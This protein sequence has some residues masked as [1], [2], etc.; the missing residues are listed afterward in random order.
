ML[1]LPLHTSFKIR[2]DALT[3][4]VVEMVPFPASIGSFSRMKAFMTLFL[5]LPDGT[6]KMGMFGQ[7]DIS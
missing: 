7:F 2:L 4:P 3:D 5:K 1:V 6:V